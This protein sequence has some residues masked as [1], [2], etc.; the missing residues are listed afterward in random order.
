MAKFEYLDVWSSKETWGGLDPPE[1]GSLVVIPAGKT[2]MLD[3]DTPVLKM[4]L[5]QG[6]ESSDCV[7]SEVG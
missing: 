3:V 1:E 4:L 5:I 6:R 2:V 7:M